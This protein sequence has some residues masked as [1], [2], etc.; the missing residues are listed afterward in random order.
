MTCAWRSSACCLGLTHDA[1]VTDRIG[2]NGATSMHK[3]ASLVRAIDTR[4][5]TTITV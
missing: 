2:W 1:R 3:L 4:V 5:V